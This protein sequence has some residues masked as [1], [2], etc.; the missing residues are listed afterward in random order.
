MHTKL[1]V[2]HGENVTVIR[3]CAN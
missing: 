1:F 2:K 3:T